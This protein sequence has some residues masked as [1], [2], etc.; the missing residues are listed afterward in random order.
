[1]MASN[2]EKQKPWL[3]DRYS[4]F[5]GML[6]VFFSNVSGGMIA[7][8]FVFFAFSASGQPKF[9]KRIPH[10]SQ[11]ENKGC[12]DY[13]KIDGSTNV[14]HF[15][16]IQTL[17]K[18]PNVVISRDPSR[19]TLV[20]KI[21]AHDFE[22]SNPMMYKDF[23]DFIKAHEFPYI[24]IT[25]FFDNFRL[26]AGNATAVV[27]R[28]KVGLAGQTKTYKIPGYLE[29]CL[30]KELHIKGRVNIDLKDFGLEPPTKFLG[31]VKVSNEVFINFAL[32]LEQ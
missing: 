18:N 32:T 9:E 23:L 3:S 14:N 22:P 27:P 20:L 31:M 7:M 25:I 2:I 29:E 6:L 21:P 1:M 12:D 26:P 10:H 28:I 4:D 30:D 5:W 17:D 15:Y 16:F 8:V 19:E 11:L 13:I 24:D